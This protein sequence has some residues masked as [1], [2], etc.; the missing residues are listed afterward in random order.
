MKETYCNPIKL[1]V[2]KILPRISTVGWG[3][4]ISHSSTKIK[5]FSKC[6]LSK[7]QCYERIITGK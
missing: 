2:I 6:K 1:Y 4:G 5:H 3:R 7:F